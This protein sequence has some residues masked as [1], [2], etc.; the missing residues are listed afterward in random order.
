MAGNALHI[1][2]LFAVFYSTAGITVSRHY[3]MNELKGVSFFGETRGC[4]VSDHKG[5]VLGGHCGR[6]DGREKG[7][8]CNDSAEYFKLEEEKQI[9]LAGFEPVVA[10]DQFV[11]IAPSLR[12]LFL[13]SWKLS[14]NY[15]LFKPPI[16]CC[17]FQS[18]LQIFLI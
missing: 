17:D 5:C 11:A 12:A 6:S 13:P 9:T 8:C 18:L 14:F 3:C 2:L 7:N 10:P 16:I 15:L 1:I 4:H